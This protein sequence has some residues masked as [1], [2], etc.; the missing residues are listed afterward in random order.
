[1]T[2]NIYCVVTKSPKL[3]FF[4]GE[5]FLMINNEKDFYNSNSNYK[6]FQIL[7]PKEKIHGIYKNGKV[8]ISEIYLRDY[9]ISYIEVENLEKA[10]E[11]SNKI[12]NLKFL[13]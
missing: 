9:D 11:F 3:D 8:Y 1:M 5:I 7:N 4:I 10:K 6:T 12:K 2:D 13:I